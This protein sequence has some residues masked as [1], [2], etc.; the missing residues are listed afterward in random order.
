MTTR[1]P[2][3]LLNPSSI[4]VFRADTSGLSSIP[5]G[6]VAPTWFT[7]FSKT[8]DTSAAFDTSTGRFTPQVAGYYQ[9]NANVSYS[10]SGITATYVGAVIGKNGTAHRFSAVDSSGGYPNIHVSDVVYLNG[11]TD[12][13]Q[14]GTLHNASGSVSDISAAISGCLIRP[15]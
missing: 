12:Y 13:V 8:F 3:Q 4:P 6:L 5:T 1:V 10:S 11:T 9:I 14:V 7:V 15:E 2:H